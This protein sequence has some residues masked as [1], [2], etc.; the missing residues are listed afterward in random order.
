MAYSLGD[1]YRPLR[2]ILRLNGVVLG[3]LLGALLLLGPRSLL[4]DMA[5]YD[6]GPLFPLRAAGAAGFAYGV[7]MVFGSAAR[8]FDL[9]ALI[10]CVLFHGLLAVILLLGYLRGEMA[11]LGLFGQ[12]CLVILFVLCLAGALVPLRYFR[13]EFRF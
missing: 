13:A 4:G 1:P 8:D 6:G 5:L 3:L 10:S 2:T 12:I 11:A 9:A 7:W